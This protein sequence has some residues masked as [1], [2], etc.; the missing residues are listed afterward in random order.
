MSNTSNAPGSGQ[1]QA[2]AGSGASRKYLGEAGEIRAGQGF[3]AERL[4]AYLKSA[5]PGYRGPLTIQQFD[6]GQSNLTYRINTPGANY[7]LR[8]KPPGVL[9]KSAHAVDREF[10]VMSALFRQGFPV[11]EPLVLCEDESVVG[12]MFYVMRH[13]PGRIFWDCT[14]PDLTR[15]H[16]AAVFDSVNATLAALHNFAPESI[17]LGDFGKPGNYFARQ[18]T[19]WSGQYVA[20]RTQDIPEMDRLIA[21]LPT[22]VPADDGRASVV[23]GDFSFHNVLIH[24][25]E[26]RVVAVLDWE[27]S[28][29]GHPLGDLTYHLMEWYRPAGIDLRGTLAGQD[30]AALGIPTMDEYVGR[31]C[32]RAGIA[33]IEN[34]GFYRAFNLFR[35]AA[36]SQGI[37]GRIAEGTAASTNAAEVATRVRP[38]AV[39]AW[40]EA[41]AAG[42]R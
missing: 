29:L 1:D 23:H 19:R 16:R 4:D 8:R 34:L 38:L 20:S 24:P 9:L 6:G 28:T 13:V 40:R 39:A 42:A 7:V 25:T 37:A 11:P 10:R 41:C 14:M 31:Y 21:W 2:R 15:E 12:T 36:I 33:P 3:E 32:A 18:I 17:G 35:I 26:P 5:V 27:L 30:L 22:A